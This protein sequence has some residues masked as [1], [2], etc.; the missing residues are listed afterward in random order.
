VILE[1]GAESQLPCAVAIVSKGNAPMINRTVSLLA[2]ICAAAM[3]QPPSYV[4]STLAGGGILPVNGPA[5]T[6]PVGQPQG[7]AIDSSGNIFFTNSFSVFKSD[8]AGFVT[9]VAG[10][11]A[12]GDSGDGGPAINARFKGLTANR[13]RPRRQ[14]LRR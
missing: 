9:R 13:P 7:I 8:G 5:L 11:G 10:T 4:I 14:Y 12:P 3:A 2:A 6:T 1:T